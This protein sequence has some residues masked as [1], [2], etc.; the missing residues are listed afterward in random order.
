MLFNYRVLYHHFIPIF[1]ALQHVRGHLANNEVV[2]PVGR[3]AERNTVRT[4]AD[5]PNLGNDDPGARSPRVSEVDD[6]QP[7]HSD[8]GPT[9]SRVSLPLILVLGEDDGDNDV[10]GGHS[11][12]ADDKDGLTTELVD[13]CYSGEGSEPHDNTNDTGGEER[14]GVAAQTEV[15][16]DRG[17][18]VQDSVDTLQDYQRYS[19]CAV[20]L[21]S[22]NSQ[23]IAGKTW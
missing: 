10:A 9:S 17:C 8:G 12:G 13:V 15:L 18:V 3:S 14:G 16:E 23:S 7:D 1:E 4:L 21:S 5:G 2:H 6:E 20:A 11:N 22:V 19:T